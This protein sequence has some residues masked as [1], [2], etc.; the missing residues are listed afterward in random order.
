[1]SQKDWDICPA[2]EDETID[3]RS[4]KTAK[5]KGWND[6]LKLR[7]E[8]GVGQSGRDFD[9]DITSVYGAAYLEYDV[10]DNW[11]I[12]A[13]VGLYH[14]D[15]NSILAFLSVRR[16][17]LER[18]N[19]I[20]PYAGIKMGFGFGKSTRGFDDIYKSARLFNNG[21][22]IYHNGYFPDSKT[23]EKVSEKEKNGVPYKEYEGII[24][25]E[26]THQGPMCLIGG[27]V[28]F[29][30]GFFLGVTYSLVTG[31]QRAA[32]RKVWQFEDNTSYV[33]KTVTSSTLVPSNGVFFHVGW[34]F[35]LK[36]KNKD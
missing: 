27:G 8:S 18:K 13:G 35:L 15:E 23:E 25:I 32:T 29:A 4:S 34:T 12:G 16:Y 31:F 20:R 33:G 19:N 10:K 1:M 26:S 14:D 30:R 36:K 21:K 17:F 9:M 6:G 24:E 11:A 7:I 28:E 5:P 2:Y 22:Y 3:S